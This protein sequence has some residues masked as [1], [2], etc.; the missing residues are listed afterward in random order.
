MDLKNFKTTKEVQISPK[1]IDQII[2]QDE[3]LTIIKKAASQRRNVL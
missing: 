1:I 3:A 2:G